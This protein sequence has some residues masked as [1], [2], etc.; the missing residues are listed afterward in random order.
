MILWYNA[1]NE[2][3]F[4]LS[5]STYSASTAKE[6]KNFQ[7]KCTFLNAVHKTFFWTIAEYTHIYALAYY[8]KT[9]GWTPLIGSGVCGAQFSI[10]ERASWYIH[11]GSLM[12]I[13]PDK[14]LKCTTGPMTLSWWKPRRLPVSPSRSI[15]QV[16]AQLFRSCDF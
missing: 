7:I 9:I 6:Q 16:A 14:S 1:Y 5:Q 4:F 12:M 8:V 2:N 10:Y 11:I 15:V 3:A 13:E